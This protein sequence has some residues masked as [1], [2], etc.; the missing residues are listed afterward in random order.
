MNPKNLPVSACP[1]LKL[2]AHMVTWCLLKM[3]ICMG[4][5]WLK[6]QL[7]GFEHCCFCRGPRLIPSTYTMAF[8]HLLTPVLWHAFWFLWAPG[9]HMALIHICRQN[10]HNIFKKELKPICMGFGLFMLTDWVISASGVGD[11]CG[12]V[13][14][15]WLIGWLIGWLIDFCLALNCIRPG[16]VWNSSP[17]LQVL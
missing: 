4:V 10:T 17:L 15:D 12:K 9:I 5:C 13:E 11:V 3:C 1:V 8:K 6:W 14:I 2:E 7:S 16:L